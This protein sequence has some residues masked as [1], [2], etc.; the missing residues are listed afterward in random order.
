MGADSVNPVPVTHSGAELLSRAP[1]AG[2]CEPIV[3]AR[4]VPVVGLV[5][6][7]VDVED[8]DDDAGEL[9]NHALGVW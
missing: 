5:S 7:P 9:E 1:A 6:E 8:D 4:L 3:V 2:G